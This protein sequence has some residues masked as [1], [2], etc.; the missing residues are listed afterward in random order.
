MGL[1]DTDSIVTTAGH[2]TAGAIGMLGWYPWLRGRGLVGSLRLP[3]FGPR[4]VRP[5]LA[6]G[7]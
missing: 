2:L 1:G 3:S 5:A 7:A 4:A 6:T